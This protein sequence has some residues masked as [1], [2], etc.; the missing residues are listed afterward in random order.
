MFVIRSAWMFDVT[1]SAY[2][3]FCELSFAL[4]FL[5]IKVTEGTFRRIKRR[6][7]CNITLTRTRLSTWTLL[8]SYIYQMWLKKCHWSNLH[9][10]KLVLNGFKWLPGFV[11]RLELHWGKHTHTNPNFGNELFWRVVLIGNKCFQEKNTQ[12]Q[13][14]PYDLTLCQPHGACEIKLI[15]GVLLGDCTQKSV[16]TVLEEGDDQLMSRAP[17]GHWGHAPD[18]TTLGH[19]YIINSVRISSHTLNSK[20]SC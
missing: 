1:S 10:V 18:P 2:P 3:H 11:K 15:S 7:P 9:E 4:L 5:R 6:W 12:T 13:L 16:S 14:M 8:L 20:L 19:Y 17:S